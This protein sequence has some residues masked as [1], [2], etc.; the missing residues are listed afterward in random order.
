MN[1]KRILSFATI[2]SFLFIHLSA[3]Q[4]EQ[5]I[6]VSSWNLENLFDTIDDPGTH[7]TEFTPEGEGNWT[8]A[9]MKKK[10]ENLAD[11][12]RTFDNKE[13][14]DI[15]GVQEVEH[16]DLLDSLLY[17]FPSRDYSIVYEESPDYRGIDN[18]LIYDDEQFDLLEKHTY[19]VELEGKYTTRLILHAK[20]STGNEN[21]HVL[22]NHWPSRSGGMER[23]K[24]R[25]IAAATVLRNAVDKIF[26]TEDAPNIIVLGDFNDEPENESINEVLSTKDFECSK[27]DNASSE[28]Y[29]LSFNL[30]DEGLG[31][32]MYRG[33]WNMLD[34]IIVSGALADEDGWSYRCGSFEILKPSIMVTKSGKYE[35]AAFPTYGGSNYL[36]GY[37]DH[38]PVGAKFI[39]KGGK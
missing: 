14:P 28:M 13:G 24:P 32:Y 2:L 26:E 11:V 38:Y 30:Y 22:V 31:T 18:G 20:L 34:Q 7:D 4:S 9:R 39:L 10:I 3:Q 1:I 6:Y 36:G 12:I 21:L 5:Y 15:L 25:R 16:K 23:T 35:G 8:S 33:E 37:S 19:V 27:I 29:N 17:Y